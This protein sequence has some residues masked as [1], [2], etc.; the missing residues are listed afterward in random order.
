MRLSSV[1]ALKDADLGRGPV[2]VVLAEDEV[3]VASTLAHLARA[4]FGTRILAIEA[5]VAP[6][7]A[8]DAGTIRVDVADTPRAPEIVNAVARAV[9]GRWVHY[10]FNAEYLFFPFCDHRRV[11]EMLAFHADER[12]EAMPTHVVD[13]YARDLE[14]APDGV[15]PDDACFDRLGYFAEPRWG[16]PEARALDRQ[17]D[18]FGGLRWR[19]A[20]HVPKRQRRIDRIGLFRATP[21]AT[22]RSDHTFNVPEMNTHACPWHRNLTAAVCSFRAA[23]ALRRNPGSRHR[24]AD[25]RWHGSEPFDWRP[26]RLMDLGL[27]EPGQWF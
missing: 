1:K 15:A 13:L 19:Y 14:A 27:M 12:R 6:G 22:L 8:L 4:G 17:L 21:G 24:I 7:L 20:E 26:Q 25:F 18:L 2:A 23:K 16:G 11:G 5:D 10:C 9:P 3:E